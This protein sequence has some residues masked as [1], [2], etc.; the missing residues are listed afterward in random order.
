MNSQEQQVHRL[1]HGLAPSLPEPDNRISEIGVRVRRNRAVRA[2]SAMSV[3]ALAVAAIVAVPV[4]RFDRASIGDP[5]SGGPET[6]LKVSASTAAC[7]K[8]PDLP[9]GAANLD[10]AA[11]R[12]RGVAESQYTD[13]FANLEITDRVRVFRKQSAD[14]DSWIIRNFGQVCVELVDV[15]YSGAELQELRDRV[16]A[17]R[18][19]WR[20]RGIEL[21][22]VAVGVEGTITI[23]VNEAVYDTAV[24]II[25]DRYPVPVIIQKEGPVKPA[26]G[27]DGP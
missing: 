20:T 2:A 21:N 19:F 26:I 9:S 8:S 16:D 14:F 1:L 3:A 15:P 5:A 6:S 12:L 4:L 27:R 10:S 23:G 17:D 22:T 18:S 7:I 13:S 11:S 25:P 24:D